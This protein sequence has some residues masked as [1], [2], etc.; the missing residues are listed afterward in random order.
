MIKAIL[1]DFNGVIIDDE[2]IQLKAYQSVLKDYGIDLTNE[3]Y[4][5]SLGMDDRRFVEAAFARSGVPIPDGALNDVL[6]KK[7][8]A[9]RGMIEDELPLFPGVVTF[10]KETSRHCDLGI[11]SM[12]RRTEIDFVLERSG[13]KS[14]FST[15]ISA[16]DVTECKPNPMC[17]EKGFR[18]LD[19]ARTDMSKFAITPSECLVIEDAPPGIEAAKLAGLRTLA[20][21]NTVPAATLR[22]AGA[23]VVTSSLSDWSMDA[24]RHVFER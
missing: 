3:D 4:Y 2:P 18:L 17:Y 19:R 7:S 6:D 16:E 24:V 11:V 10:V 1:F 12:A 20:V 21:T 15:V 8:I 23:D 5:S 13:L 22:E 14:Y 9:H